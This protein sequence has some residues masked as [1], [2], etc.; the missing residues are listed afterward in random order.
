MTYKKLKQKIKD[1]QKKRASNIHELKEARKPSIYNANPSYYDKLGN[2]GRHQ[3]DYRHTHIAYCMFFNKTPYEKI[4]KTCIESPYEG[5]I[6]NLKKEWKEQL[7][8]D[9]E[10]ICNN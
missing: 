6:N 3:Y 10:T 4:E 1:L 9:N 8:D 2:L 7:G 5:Y